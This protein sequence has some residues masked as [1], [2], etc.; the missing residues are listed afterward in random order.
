[1]AI[2]LHLH[3]VLKLGILLCGLFMS[4]AEEPSTSSHTPTMRLVPPRGIVHLSGD[5]NV[6]VILN[7]TNDSL[8]SLSSIKNWSIATF[9]PRPDIALIVPHLNIIPDQTTNDSLRAFVV[10]TGGSKLGTVEVKVTSTLELNDGGVFHE[11][12]MYGVSTVR[13]PG[14]VEANIILV[15]MSYLLLIL[16]VL[17]V[18]CEINLNYVKNCITWVFGTFLIHAVLVPV[19]SAESIIELMTILTIGNVHLRKTLE[20][21]SK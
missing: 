4:M 3:W 20:M 1:M 5:L 16:L 19:V 12:V 15:Y 17:V 8:L 2:S 6:I 21:N 18:C 13:S 9:S 7:I 14:R 11:T 10:V